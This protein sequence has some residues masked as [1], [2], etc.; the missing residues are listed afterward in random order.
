[1][2]QAFLKHTRMKALVITTLFVTLFTVSATAGL[3]SYSIYLNNKL[4][5]KQ[6]VNQPL[7][8]QGLQLDNAQ[9]NDQLVI[10]YSQCQAP[11]K[12]GKDRRIAVKDEQGNTIK[13]W[14]FADVS[15]TDNG[16]RIPVKELLEL[17]KRSKGNFTLVYAA[18]Q[19]PQ[20][21]TLTGFQFG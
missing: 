13:E 17:K 7:N 1:M 11:N 15:G 9:A 20:G 4:V 8:L 6:A 5:L 2:Q 10:Y 18:S 19:L 16:M 12:I 3:D 21:Q 14:K